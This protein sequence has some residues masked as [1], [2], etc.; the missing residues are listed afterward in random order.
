[1]KEALIVCPVCNS[2]ISLLVNT[3]K[4]PHFWHAPGKL[5]VLTPLDRIKV[6]INKLI[7]DDEVGIKYTTIK[8]DPHPV[9]AIIP[10]ELVRSMFYKSLNIKSKRVTYNR[11]RVRMGDEYNA[12]KCQYRV[13]IGS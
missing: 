11:A 8:G 12:E 6:I 4:A 2:E 7:E 3:P 9:Y 1:M 10:E 5:D 13:K